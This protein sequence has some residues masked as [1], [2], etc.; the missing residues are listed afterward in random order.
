M[1]GDGG[2]YTH[3][4]FGFGHWSLGV[5]LWLVVI[6]LVVFLIKTVFNTNKS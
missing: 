4:G 2:F 3:W 6:V 5:L 1:H